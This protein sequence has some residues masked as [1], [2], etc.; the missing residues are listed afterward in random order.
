MAGSLQQAAQDIIALQ[1]FQVDVFTC[2]APAFVRGRVG[3]TNDVRVGVAQLGVHPLTDFSVDEFT[4]TQ[5]AGGE[6]GVR[7]GRCGP[8][9]GIQ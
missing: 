6:G 8:L 4:C 7:G 5:P 3:L 1:S 9:C 2:F